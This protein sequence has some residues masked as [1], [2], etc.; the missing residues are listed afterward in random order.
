MYYLGETFEGE[1][2]SVTIKLGYTILSQEMDRISA[3]AM[4]QESDLTKKFQR[5]IL[6]HLTHFFGKRLI[7]SEYCITKLG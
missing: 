3:A 2:L 1:F 7:V 4:W 5:I 6:R